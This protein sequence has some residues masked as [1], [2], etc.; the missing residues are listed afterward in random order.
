MCAIP[1]TLPSVNI[2]PNFT[3]TYGIFLQEGGERGGS[4][5]YW[6]FGTGR[7]LVLNCRGQEGVFT[8]PL[9]PF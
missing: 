6:L 1:L 8:Y 2:T 7:R 5:E 3:V 9:C 4:E